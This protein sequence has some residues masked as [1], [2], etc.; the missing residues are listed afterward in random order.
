MLRRILLAFSKLVLVI[1][2]PPFILLTNLYPLMT[3]AFLRH[4]YGKPDF[5]PSPGFTQE[6]RLMVAEKAIFYLLTDADIDVLR[7]LRGEEGPLFREKELVHM[8]DVKILTWRAFSFHALLGLLIATSVIALLAVRETRK[9]LPLY[10][11]FGSLVTIALLLLTLAVVN[12]RFGWWF[13]EFHRVFFGPDE[14]RWLF[15]YSDALIRLFPPRFW[16]DAAMLIGLLTIGE[17]A[18]LGA[19]MY[20]LSI[21]FKPRI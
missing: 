4:E 3:S 8:V 1:C 16:F 10:I 19:A 13:I 15:D 12:F 7:D 2:I 9:R 5:P 21:K 18:I 17:A 6:E 11:F 20:W 14:E